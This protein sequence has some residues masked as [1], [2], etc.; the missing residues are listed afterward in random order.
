VDGM[1]PWRALSLIAVA[2]N[3]G[4]PLTVETPRAGV[5][6]VPQGVSPHAS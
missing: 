6:A 3:T 1:L 2:R 4:Q 5:E